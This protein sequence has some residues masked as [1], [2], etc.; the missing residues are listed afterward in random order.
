MWTFR[1][2]FCAIIQEIV[3]DL[4]VHRYLILKRVEIPAKVLFCRQRI[5]HW[6]KLPRRLDS[7]IK[8]PL[9]GPFANVVSEQRAPAKWKGVN[10]HEARN[11]V[12]MPKR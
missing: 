12:E 6:W 4:R 11:F 1:Q 7:L 10:T 9:P 3:W 8:P 2:P 5:N